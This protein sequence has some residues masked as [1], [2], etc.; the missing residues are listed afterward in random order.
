[1]TGEDNDEDGRRDF[2]FLHGSWRVA[3]RKLADNWD[4]DCTQWTRFSST[5]IVRP[6]LANLA[7]MDYYSTTEFPGNGPMEGI[8]LRLFNPRTRLWRIWWASTRQPGDLDTPVEG[9]FSAGVGE[10][11]CDDTLNGRPLRVRYEWTRADPEHPRWTQAFSYDGGTTWKP[12][13]IM[14]LTRDADLGAN[15]S[16]GLS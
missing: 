14:E 8:A 1:M 2:D 11:Y 3:N 12:N 4:P 6:L 13:W 10:F 9:R 15:G 16:T 5:V 7:V